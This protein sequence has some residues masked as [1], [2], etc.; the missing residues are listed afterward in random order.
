MRVKGSKVS[1]P[2]LFVTNAGDR[3]HINYSSV[4]NPD[5]TI[6]LVPSGKDDIQEMYDAQRDLCDMAYMINRLSLG[7]TSVLHSGQP[8]Y[9]DFTKVPTS[10]VE[11]LQMMIDAKKAFYDLPSEVRNK[12]DGDFNQWFVQ[13]GSSDWLEKMNISSDSSGSIE[14]EVKSD[15]S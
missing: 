11:V 15:E 10:Q 4:V 13:S 7:D 8:I 9:G 6:S 12:F 3:F 1:D 5:G 14:S 2:N